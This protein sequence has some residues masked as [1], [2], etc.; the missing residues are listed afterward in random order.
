MIT[1]LD[2]I[3]KNIQNAK[4]VSD[5]DI[6]KDLIRDDNVSY[7]KQ[8]MQI[9]EDYYNI[10]NS[11][12][13]DKV[14]YY[15]KNGVKVVD[16]FVSNNKM[17]SAFNKIIV[18]QSVNYSIG[19]DPTITSESDTEK[20]N[21]S[22]V[23]KSVIGKRIFKEVRNMKKEAAKKG[24]S[25][26]Y[27]FI[28]S[29]G[30]FDYI[31]FDP[32][33][34]IAIYDQSLEKELLQIIRYYSIKVVENG[35]EKLRKKVEIYDREK[36]TYY[37]ET[38]KGD[39]APIIPLQ[40]DPTV[41]SNPQYY[42]MTYNTVDKE[43][44]EYHGWG[45]VPFVCLKN[46][47]DEIPEIQLNKQYIDAY[48]NTF[49]EMQNSIDDNATDYYKVKGYK[50]NKDEG[51]MFIHNL[52]T[53]Q[54]VGVSSDGDFD[55]VSKDVQVESKITALEK[56]RK[57]IFDFGMAV[58]TQHD[59]V[60]NAASGKSLKYQY[61][62]LNMKASDSESEIEDFIRDLFGLANIYI[63]INKNLGINN[64]NVSNVNPVDIDN[65]IVK[66]NRESILD[67]DLLNALKD[68]VGIIS[69]ETI[70]EVHPLVHDPVI[71]AKRMKEQESMNMEEFNVPE[72]PEEEI[73]EEES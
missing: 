27:T 57:D 50:V 25:W 12:I 33:E 1:D 58:D 63:E 55:R 11:K 45:V 32:R 64:P 40:E 5:S 41:I 29:K 59:K 37:M 61:A 66:F 15:Y 23:L 14:K 3:K 6:L 54:V 67:Y 47:S 34:I 26:L 7:S 71:E 72:V 24:K 68:Q 62:L 48:D 53:K 46:N 52:K 28:N 20:D 18:D 60:G 49:S 42:F 10:K 69:N 51:G 17:P 44:V 43:K 19:T 31:A 4:I 16:E 36:I 65:L 38:K 30:E 73:I 35:E 9:G 2:V 56:L 70:W 8:L 22:N 21:I 13:L 39:F